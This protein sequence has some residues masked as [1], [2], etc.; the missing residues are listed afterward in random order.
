[1]INSSALL[2]DL[3]RVLRA[4]EADLRARIDEQAS[5]S[6]SLQAE[7]KDARD[8]GRTGVR[9]TEWLDDE[10]TQAADQALTDF[11]EQELT[12]FASEPLVHY[13]LT[14]TRIEKDGQT[15]L[16]VFHP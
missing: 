2:A 12:Q 5:L 11:P 6:E 16:D 8:A 7:W 1:M 15:L 3:R 14:T 4:L 9:Y 13:A 10:I